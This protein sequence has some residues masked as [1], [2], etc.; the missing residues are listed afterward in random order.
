MPDGYELFTPPVDISIKNEIGELVINIS[1][2]GSKIEI[3]RSWELFS[4]VI[5][6]EMM[7]EFREMIVAWEKVDY[8][9]I[10]LKKM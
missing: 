6:S 1:Q 2:S 8:R 4:D 9:K 5:S 7:D 3:E 10:V